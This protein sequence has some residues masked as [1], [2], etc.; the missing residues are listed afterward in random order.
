[1]RANRG[2]FFVLNN[3]L[4]ISNENNSELGRK[5]LE[6]LEIIILTVAQVINAQVRVAQVGV[7]HN[8]ILRLDFIYSFSFYYN[9]TPLCDFLNDFLNENKHRIIASNLHF[10]GNYSKC[11]SSWPSFRHA[12]VRFDL[13][14]ASNYRVSAIWE[15]FQRQKEKMIERVPVLM[16]LF[17]FQ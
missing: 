1:M 14:Q 3:I 8:I 9:K 16:L 15:I 7:N 6:N 4:M 2:L 11:N 10:L 12:A 13:K 5:S 17:F